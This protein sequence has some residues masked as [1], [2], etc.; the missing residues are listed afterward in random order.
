[1]AREYRES[2]VKLLL[3]AHLD[4]LKKI[5]EG[6]QGIL[7]INKNMLSVLQYGDHEKRITH[8]E[9]RPA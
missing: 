2:E 5:N 7:E 1:M 6:I 3:E 8:L 9:V 4:Q